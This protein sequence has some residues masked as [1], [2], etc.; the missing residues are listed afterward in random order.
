MD[1]FQKGMWV[2]TLWDP[3]KEREESPL[4]GEKQVKVAAYCRVSTD[5]EA[6]IRSL[7]N[8]VHH[9][10]H[11]IR[12]KPN[13]KFV[14]VYFDS[15]TSGSN[16]K[17]QRGLQRLLR[18]CDE[19]RVDYILTKDVSRLTRNAE[20]L[21]KI[22]ED[23][24][25]KNVGIYFEKEQIDTS[26]TFNHFLLTTYAALAQE[27]IENLSTSTKW[28][29]EKKFQ[30]GEAKFSRLYGYN[31]VRDESGSTLEIN[32]QEAAVVRN[33]FD[34]FLQGWSRT[35]MTRELYR[36]GVKTATGK[37]RWLPSNIKK[38]LKSYTYT[39]NM[40]A[41]TATRDLFTHKM[42]YHDREEIEIANTHPPIISREVFD[43]VQRRIESN[44][45]NTGKPTV[46]NRPAFS[47]KLYCHACGYRYKF[48]PSPHIDYWKC[49]SSNAKTCDAP[50]I[51]E[52]QLK[53]MALQAM[54]LKYEF[55]QTGTLAQLQKDLK[56]TNQQDHFEFHRL[57]WLTEL[58]I[59]KESN[60]DPEKINA[61]ENEYRAFEKQV[62]RIED[63]RPFR[64]KTLKWLETLQSMEEFHQKVTTE[65]LRAWIHQITIESEKNYQVEWFDGTS[66]TVGQ[67]SESNSI[68]SS[69]KEEKMKKESPKK[70]V[71]QELNLLDEHGALKEK[72][73]KEMN[74]TVEREVQKI[75]P[76]EGKVILQTIE[77]ARIG[78]EKSDHL[79]KRPKAL[80][81]AAYCR[82]STDRLEQKTSMKT[83]VAYYTYLILKDPSYEFAGIYADE[84]IT[85]RSLEKRDQLNQLLKDCE[86]GL[87]NVIITKSISRFSRNALDTL[88]IA[89]HLKQ[90]ST[91]VYIYFEKENIWTSDPQSELMMS[92]YGAIAQEEVMNIGKSIAWGHRSQAKRGIIRW[93]KATYGYW[94]DEDYR[95]HIQPEQAKVIQRIYSDVLSG[96]NVNKICED[97]A[98]DGIKTATGKDYWNPKSVMAML[99]NEVYKGDYLF[100]KHVTVDTLQSKV[101][102]N[103]GEEPQYYIENHHEAII[104]PKDWDRVQDILEERKKGFIKD[105]HRKYEKDEMKNE[106]FIEKLYCGECGYLMGHRRHVERRWKKPFETHFWVCCRHDQRYRNER[107][108]TRRIRQDYLEWNF[109][110]FLNQ[111]HT[112]PTFKNDVLHW[113]K[114]LELTDEEKQEKTDLQERV[115]NQNQALYSAVEEGIHES[116]QNTQLVDKL[117]EELV[118]LHDRLKHFSESERRVE[119]ESKMF[120]EIMKKVKKYVEGA[121]ED[122]PEELFQEFISRAEVCKDGK[123]TYHLIFEMEQKMPG[124]YTDYVEIKSQQ[125]KQQTKEKHEALLKGPEVA[126]LLVYCVEPKALKEIVDFMNERMVISDSHIFQVLLRP[127]MKQGKL[128]RF[129]APEKG[130][131]REVF[132]YQLSKDNG[133]AV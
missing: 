83:Q 66:L 47:K 76:G 99:T 77:N 25:A 100:Q 29:Y 74:T 84:G 67:L 122:F 94:V 32:D 107:C 63:D 57:K 114:R 112:D 120:K 45:R 51:N 6:Q 49:A 73:E 103:Q 108:D 87:V 37:D 117:T 101:I 130:G 34:W 106:A 110:R 19:G 95:W 42:T 21:M 20:H 128:E 127:L 86:R 115:E 10:T 129:K 79:Q 92:I 39:G 91:P 54:S 46:R 89:R 50:N 33:I 4:L 97:L 81:T 98:S 133:F 113:I 23:L 3:V 52:E 26:I 14:G 131:T 40:I 124:T 31:L 36:Q 8:Q 78:N 5:F 64:V 82:V 9:Y 55:D 53:Q 61:L 24:K 126:E 16:A 59:A 7:E 17:K 44:K 1:E 62:A 41:R 58:E 125:K 72:R 27:E 35:E 43:E 80:K 60:E 18:H 12:S 71:N 28:G 2:R 56:A 96:K 121:S 90:L 38:M 111:I 15:G 116:G 132:H 11:L 85:G 75:E 104:K 93:K 102:R 123:V 70:E 109:I 13:W 30:K 105:G 22:V 88:S 48:F 118:E 68:H 65:Y 69:Q 119:H